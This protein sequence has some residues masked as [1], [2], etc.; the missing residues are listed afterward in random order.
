MIA[1][2]YVRCIEHGII[3]VQQN[4]AQS[5][6]ITVGVNSGE[7]KLIQQGNTIITIE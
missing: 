5:R 6:R 1:K 7:D 3:V 4:I 2:K